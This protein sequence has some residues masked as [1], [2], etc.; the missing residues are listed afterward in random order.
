MSETEVIGV[1]TWPRLPG[2]A[3]V[4]AATALFVA[5]GG[6]AIAASPVV[7]RALFADNAAKLQGKTAAA[8]AQQAAQL[9]GPASTAAGLVSIKS[10]TGITLPAADSTSFS[11]QVVPAACDAG[12]KAISAGYSASGG[13]VIEFSR[14]P[15]GDSSWNLELGNLDDRGPSSVTVY[16]VCLG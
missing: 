10:T 1:T 7:K 16:A 15:L 11:T 5:F 9:P 12:K 14:Q 3:T 6:T 8:I 13:T 4:L 2:P